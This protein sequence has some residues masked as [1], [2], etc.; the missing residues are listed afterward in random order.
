MPDD[1]CTRHLCHQGQSRDISIRASYAVHQKVLRM[2]A[3]F[4]IL[5]REPYKFTY[6]VEVTRF[7]GPD[8]H[9]FRAAAQIFMFTYLIHISSA[10]I[11]Q[12]CVENPGRYRIR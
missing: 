1:T 11:L 2:V 7:F 9:T 5:E 10:R 3:L 4:H 12:E 6:N 8:E